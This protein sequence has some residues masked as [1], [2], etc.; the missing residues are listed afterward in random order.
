MPKTNKEI[1]IQIE[2]AM[3]SLSEQSKPNIAKTA[4]EFA[5]P[6]GRLRRRW[7]GGKSLFQRKPNG[8]RLNSIQEQALCEYINYFDT[9][10]ASI[11]RR[12]IAIAANSI[13]EEDHHDESEP[14]PQIGDHW[15]K[16]FLKRNPEYYVRRRKAL[17]VERS[18]ALDKSVV[19][20]WF[21]DYKQV[22]TEH[23]ICQQDIYNFDETGFQ[24]GVG[25]DQ[26]II[27][28][29]PKKK[30]F[31]GSITNR[32]SVT[33]LEAV[34]ADGFACPPLIILSA[35]QALAR[36]F[37][38]IKEDEHLALGFK[39]TGL[40]PIN[41]KLITDELESYDPYY[42][43]LYRSNTPSINSQN[44]EFSTPKTA[45]KVRRI[46]LRLN[47]YDPTTQHFKEGLAKLAKGAE[48]QA[49]LALQ[50]Q[51]EFD[52]TQAIMGARHARYDASRR[53]VRIT[54]IMNSNQLKEI[55]RKEYKL[56]EKA[57]QEKTRRKWKKVL[58]EIRKHG[59][60]KKRSGN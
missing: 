34:S 47:Q 15:L 40:W 37:D 30:L 7:K 33:V 25:R 35:K 31:N 26:F 17:D 19:E 51:R 10:G 13:L 1:E 41:S 11:N 2:K 57:D 60:A 49:T 18:A 53:H 29:H 5:V 39:L 8:R 32:E 23:G 28:R 14:P 9:V 48:A 52:R 45:E 21:Q 50:L 55:K 42:D 43:N 27:T 20:R 16:R 24:I 22:V 3:D 56:S 36:W 59:R 4:R 12:Q 44:T 38:A 54:G 58:V 46:S 6:E